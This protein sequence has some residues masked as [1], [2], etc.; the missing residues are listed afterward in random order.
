MDV[1]MSTRMT[2]TATTNGSI[3]DL[4]RK[5]WF[6]GFLFMGHVMEAASQEKEKRK[7]G[8]NGRTHESL[9]VPN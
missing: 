5:Q 1:L 6:K 7:D 9:Y 4:K 3:I 2:R 8:Q